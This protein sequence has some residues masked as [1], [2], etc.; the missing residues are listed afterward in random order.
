MSYLTTVKTLDFYKNPGC[1]GDH[2]A[3]KLFD[4]YINQK[5]TIMKYQGRSSVNRSLYNYYEK[6]F[7]K[8]DKRFWWHN[9]DQKYINTVLWFLRRLKNDIDLD[10]EKKLFCNLVLKMPYHRLISLGFNKEFNQAIEKRLGP[11]DQ[12]GQGF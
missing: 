6:I 4:H 7:I 10:R 11:I 5:K 1:I 9:A 12:L 3:I 8:N 2:L